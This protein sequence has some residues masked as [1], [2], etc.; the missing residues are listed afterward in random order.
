MFN[1]SSK[2]TKMYRLFVVLCLL[3]T[4]IISTSSVAVNVAL[5][6]LLIDLEDIRQ[7]QSIPALGLVLIKNGE[8]QFAGALGITS[9][10][11]KQPVDES[12]LFRVGSV[13]KSF[14]GLA[15]LRAQQLGYFKLDDPVAQYLGDNFIINKWSNTHPVRISHLLEHTAG[16]YDITAEEFGHESPDPIS[17]EDAFR[18][19]PESRI[20]KW[21]PG[22]HS[23]YSNLGAPIV[24]Y[25]IE[26]QSGISFEDFV[27]QHIFQPL[28]MTHSS[29]LFD[30]Y[31]SKNLVKGH[32]HNGDQEIP[33]WHIAYRPFGALNSSPVEMTSFL[34]LLINNGEFAGKRLF[35]EAEIDRMRIP[36]T[37]LAAKN[38]LQHGY[39][40]GS[41]AVLVGGNIVHGHGGTAAGHLAEYRYSPLHKFGYFVALNINN[42]SAKNKVIER[43]QEYILTDISA[44]PEL[45]SQSSDITDLEA[46]GGYYEPTTVRINGLLPF[47]KIVG[48]KQLDVVDGNL[49]LKGFYGP[50]ILL[51]QFNQFHFYE[52][53][54]PVATSAI[55]QNKHGSWIIQ[56]TDTNLQQISPSVYW[57]RV[58]A[59]AMVLFTVLA[60]W[61]Y[62]LIWIPKKL[63]GKLPGKQN[64]WV[65]LLPFIS[66]PILLMPIIISSF[67]IEF[68]FQS[69]LS[70]ATQ[71]IFVILT[72]I[73]VWLVYKSK[74]WYLSKVAKINLV[75][76]SVSNVLIGMYFII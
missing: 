17:L 61:V 44:L 32:N 28:E 25:I 15:A 62:A 71:L 10:N 58:I 5:D 38:G 21:A 36:K 27:S 53:G 59:T 11:S 24:A 30:D 9:I 67:Q 16:F 12:T 7:Q 63:F 47:L 73:G 34:K 23:S 64:T 39:G 57:A 13:S 2:Q 48:L 66:L 20:V 18:L 60:G 41:Y 45:T 52:T 33:Y 6:Q 69:A 76:S 22:S 40:L 31:V 8:T 72:I 49:L 50:T 51:K 3:T 68:E 37:T 4:G 56:T 42:K 29:F 26:Q 43:I 46:L 35:S 55:S 14:V 75:L 1:A 70:A 65:R 74:D 54:E 19:T